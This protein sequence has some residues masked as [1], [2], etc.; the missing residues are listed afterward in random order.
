MRTTL[1]VIIAFVVSAGGLGLYLK[2]QPQIARLLGQGPPP[3]PQKVD[4]NGAE[5]NGIRE[6]EK[7]YFKN[8]DKEGRLASRFRAD[9]VEPVGNGRVHVTNV[10]ADFFQYAKD[11]DYPQGRTQL[12]RIRGKKGDMDVQDSA[13]G[14]GS[15]L[16]KGSSGT[17]RR[18]RLDDVVID[19][20]QD[21]SQWQKG[22]PPYITMV[23]NNVV[24]D[25]EAFELSTQSYKDADGR[26]VPP[27]QVPIHVTG[28]YLFEGRGLKMRWNELDGRLEFLEVAHGEK[29]VVLHPQ[30]LPGST[31]GAAAPGKPATPPVGAP[32]GA[33]DLAVPASPGRGPPDR[34]A[35]KGR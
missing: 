3:E 35:S 33:S 13:Q 26:V 11:K 1:F 21:I 6:G 17:P 18:G 7:P 5:V 24:F 14:A 32:V 9:Q 29:L 34:P 15:A 19:L 8:I 4:R 31:P 27:D 23:T 30:K 10:V 16:Q 22:L 2:F 25:N 12:V 28:E 20:Y